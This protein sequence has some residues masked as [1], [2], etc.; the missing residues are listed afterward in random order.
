M[1]AFDVE[2]MEAMLDR[3][4]RSLSGVQRETNQ[5]VALMKQRL[6]EAT[7]SETGWI[8]DAYYAR[9]R[10]FPP[11][12]YWRGTVK[13]LQA[14]MMQALERG[15]PLTSDELMKVQGHNPPPSEAKT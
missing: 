11:V 4:A 3:L 15:T 1:S 10:K 7:M 2:L 5:R 14:L 9:F 12:F 8:S 13:G 6:G